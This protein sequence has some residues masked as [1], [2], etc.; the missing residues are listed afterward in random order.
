MEKALD[1]TVPEYR[2]LIAVQPIFA[3]DLHW[4]GTV[5][6]SSHHEV[7]E[8][9]SHSS[10]SSSS[11]ES[12]NEALANCD[13]GETSKRFQRLMCLILPSLSLI[14]P[15]GVREPAFQNC[16]EK[17]SRLLKFLN[18]LVNNDILQHTWTSAQTSST[19]TWQGSSLVVPTSQSSP[20]MVANAP[21]WKLARTHR[22][23]R[24]EAMEMILAAHNEAGQD[25]PQIC[26]D[27]ICLSQSL[28]HLNKGI[29]KAGRVNLFLASVTPKGKRSLIEIPKITEIPVT[30]WK[31]KFALEMSNLLFKRLSKTVC[32][33]QEH[34]AKF[35]LDG[36]R[37]NESS[38]HPLAFDMFLSPCEPATH[39]QEVRCTSTT[40][41]K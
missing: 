34:E 16:V 28:K 8:L 35:Q 5:T 40:E 17:M 1:S 7:D 13:L 38:G 31:N 32:K 2:I 27:Y 33:A 29:A 11:D 24:L 22:Y 39:W 12:R 37:L 19:H 3:G 25:S 18:S 41:C 20:S 21:S 26:R 30:N 4:S 6:L 36:L 9:D 10:D 14:P 15:T 23:K